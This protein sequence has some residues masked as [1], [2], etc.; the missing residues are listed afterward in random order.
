MESRR[1]N[2]NP[3]DFLGI[4]ILT[5]PI[6]DA[7]YGYTQI[8]LTFYFFKHFKQAHDENRK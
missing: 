1:V 6:E 7:V 4:R 3:E 8:I 2:Y 5:I